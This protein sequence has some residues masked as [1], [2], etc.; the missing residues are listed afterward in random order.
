MAVNVLT[1]TNTANVWQVL[2][3]T[4]CQ[5]RSTIQFTAHN[6]PLPMQRQSREMW[7]K[8]ITQLN[9]VITSLRRR[10]C[11]KQHGYV[12]LYLERESNKA[13]CPLITFIQV[14]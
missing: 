2:F 3:L 7:L 6:A 4:L 1:Q 14:L 8:H 5:C 9:D 10:L 12:C 13:S 11:S